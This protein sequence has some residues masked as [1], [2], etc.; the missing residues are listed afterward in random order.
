VRSYGGQNPSCPR[1]TL[2]PI[3]VP[4]SRRQPL[5][6]SATEANA[7]TRRRRISWD[8]YREYLSLYLLANLALE[9]DVARELERRSIPEL[10]KA[11]NG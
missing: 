3:A 1:Y 4:A 8:D 2:T 6:M 5:V 7:D 10:V 11:R 9:T